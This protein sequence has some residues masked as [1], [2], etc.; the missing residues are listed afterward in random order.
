MRG[1]INH[2]IPGVSLV[3][4][5]DGRLGRVASVVVNLD[6]NNYDI[7]WLSDVDWE[8]YTDGVEELEIIRKFK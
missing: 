7:Y 6:S 8:I 3:K 5:R 1:N 4:H 2:F